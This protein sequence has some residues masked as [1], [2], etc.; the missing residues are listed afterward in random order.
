MSKCV[1]MRNF[2]AI[3]QSMIDLSRFFEFKDVICPPSWVFKNLDFNGQQGCKG[4]HASSCKISWQSIK[5][6]PRYG[7]FSI[8]FS[9]WCSSDSFDF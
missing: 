1:M 8:F 9:K 4:E 5:P 6:L 7:D 3:G 2:G